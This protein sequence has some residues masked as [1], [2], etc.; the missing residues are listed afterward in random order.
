[1]QLF[2][3]AMIAA[4]EFSM[5]V[6]GSSQETPPPS[7]ETGCGKESATFESVW[8]EV[9]AEESEQQ[10]PSAPPETNPEG[11][12]RPAVID[13][14]AFLPQQTRPWEFSLTEGEPE[15]VNGLQGVLA[16]DTAAVEELP[17]PQQ[18]LPIAPAFELML[19]GEPVADSTEAVPQDTAIES[20]PAASKPEIK[21]PAPALPESS[22]PERIGRISET[23]ESTVD[24][25][26]AG[27]G[28]NAAMWSAATKETT[29]KQ[30][31]SPVAPTFQAPP[32]ARPAV[33]ATDTTPIHPA[34]GPV[35]DLAL[36]LREDGMNVQ[37]R[38]SDRPE[39]PAVSV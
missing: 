31:S 7:K 16:G 17:T 15:L 9:S 30:Q 11:E 5:P 8:N 20:E 10:K 37:I 35:R 3:H 19:A 38:L 4:A 29:G 32:A 6:M 13:V 26:P 1:M 2:W 18:R 22:K 14:M 23:R 25:N 27:T 39:Q 34:S 24:S 36:N 12:A 28:N 33:A 21:G